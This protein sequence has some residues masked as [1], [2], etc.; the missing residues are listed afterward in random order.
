MRMILISA[1]RVAAAAV[2]VTLAAVSTGCHSSRADSGDIHVVASFYP[3]ADLAEFIGGAT[4]HVHVTNLTPPGGEPH[5][6]E[7][8]ASQRVAIEDADIVI[9]LGHGFQPSVEKAARKRKRTLSVLDV[10]PAGDRTLANDPHVWLDPILMQ[11]ITSAV[12]DAFVAVDADHRQE[13]DDAAAARTESLAQ[14]DS[15]FQTGLANCA[16][17]E[18]VT[19]HAAF[20]Y[21]ARRYGLAQHAIVGLEPDVEP[22]PARLAQLSDLVRRDHVTTVFTETLVSP[23]VAQTLARE[24]HVKTDVLNPIEGLTKHERDA[25]EDYISLMRRNLV[26]LRTALGC[27]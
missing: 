9:T 26:K 10:L 18:I 13:Y 17:H 4:D 12:R 11:Q 21:L 25:G 23:K 20:G 6:L 8:T 15:A 14:L 22:E 24:A 2:A 5:D 27:S 3:L 16:R 7:I 1:R 19:A